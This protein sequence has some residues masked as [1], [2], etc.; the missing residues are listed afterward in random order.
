MRRVRASGA[1]A[2][3]CLG[4]VPHPHPASCELSEPETG[5]VTA[6]IDGETLKLADGRR[7]RRSAPA[8]TT[9][10][11]CR[12]FERC[13]DAT[14]R[15][16]RGRAPLRRDENRPPRFALAQVF[17]VDGEKRL[18]LQQELVGE[19]FARLF[20]PRQSSLR[21]GAVGKRGRG[22]REATRRVEVS[23]LSRRER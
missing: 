9:P 11:P 7:C 23:R 12:G 16:Q 17:V 3:F 8:A 18:W 22:A 10:G 6:G 21:E 19:G 15:W 5:T 13:A 14:R 20:L 4:L 1:V 2:G